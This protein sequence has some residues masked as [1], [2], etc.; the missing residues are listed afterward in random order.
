MSDLTLE[1]PRASGLWLRCRS[2]SVPPPLTS[3]EDLREARRSPP[4]LGL[5]A[6]PAPPT[7]LAAPRGV[8]VGVVGVLA[9]G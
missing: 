1:S 5:P 8:E 2:A 4:P 3:G 9:V 6:P 7:G